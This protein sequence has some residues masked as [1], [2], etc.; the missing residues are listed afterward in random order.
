[1]GRPMTPVAAIGALLVGA[2]VVALAIVLV[3]FNL[4]RRH[5][6]RCAASAT[7][8]QLE[9]IY[10]LVE[11]T[12]AATSNGCVLARTNGSTGEKRCL[13]PL[14]RDLPEFPW[15]GKVIEAT[16]PTG[17]EFRFVDAIAAEPTI[18][19]CV[20]R[21]LRVPRH[22]TKNSAKARNTFAPERY[23]A[24]SAELRTALRAVCPAY[25]AELLAYLLC[26]GRESF[27]FEP[28]DQA[29]IGTSPAWVQDPDNPVCPEC[30]K[31]M[32]LVLQLP[33]TLLGDKAVRRG[34]F[35]LF[36]CVTHPHRTASL[37]QFT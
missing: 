12:G 34:T 14:P 30:R 21:P 7:P 8:D 33:G 11:Q 37:G 10:T 27:E 18:R 36:G 23:L 9:R 28:V 6:A 17:V 3:R 29:R 31:R 15:A 32:H 5:V 25:P 16:V 24:S 35:Y 2:A 13:V 20:Y 1:M 22:P 26:A 19:G 4:K